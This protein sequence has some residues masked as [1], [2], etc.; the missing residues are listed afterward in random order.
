M[1]HDLRHLLGK[2]NILKAPG[3]LS[4]KTLLQFKLEIKLMPFVI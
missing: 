4:L 1:L 2:F 3:K